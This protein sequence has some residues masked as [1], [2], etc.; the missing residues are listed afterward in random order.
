MSEHLVESVEYPVIT[1][2]Q[3]LTGERALFKT[4]DARVT[5]CTFANGESPLKE[6]KNIRLDNCKF[7]WKYPLWYCENVEV[8]DTTWFDMARAGVWYTNKIH[9]RDSIIQAPKN[10][11]HANHI[12]LNNV[13]FT[14]AAETLW[15]CDD[16][17]MKDVSARGDYFAYGSSHIFIDGLVLDGNYGFDSCKNVT[18]YNARMLT[19]DAF[20][21]CEDVTIYDSVIYGQYFGWNSKNVRLVNCTVES[22]Q[23]MCYMENLVM[24]NCKLLNS[25]L[26]F[27]YSTVNAEITTSIRSVKN[28]ISGTIKA[29]AI[30]ELI[31]DDPEID[32]GATEYI[33]G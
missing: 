29:K 12:W 22:E 19:K 20:W 31:Q 30:E 33:L 18:I 6:S 4:R 11:R 3:V 16:I 28:P 7:E 1:E 14:N 13:T 26:T 8:E 15:S 9:V 27:E 2:Y 10:F 5:F 23:G 17:I 25:D 32:H 24:E 21:N